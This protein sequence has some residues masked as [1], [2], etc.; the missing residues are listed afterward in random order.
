MDF[1]LYRKIFHLIFV[2]IIKNSNNS[3]E[4]N[5]IVFIS[6]FYFY[7]VGNFSDKTKVLRKYFMNLISNRF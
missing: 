6:T 3:K 4:F 1:I 7:I 5:F 2:L